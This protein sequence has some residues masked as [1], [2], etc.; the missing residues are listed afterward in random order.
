MLKFDYPN[1]VIGETD[2]WI[3][4]LRPDQVTLGALVLI[5]REPV[6]SFGDVSIDGFTGLKAVCTKIETML[7]SIVHYQKINYLMLMMVDNDVHFHVFPRYEGTKEMLGTS[8]VDAGWP[9]P[10]KLDHAVTLDSAA[11][12]MLVD[13]MRQHWLEN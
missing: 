10:P 13:A 3:V 8:V 2:H 9:G 1:N 7:Q 5:S 12:D 4:Q 6:Q 11:R